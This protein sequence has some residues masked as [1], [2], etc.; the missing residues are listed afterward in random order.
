[1]ADTDQGRFGFAAVF[2]ESGL[3]V[4]EPFFSQDKRGY[5]MK[6]FEASFFEDHGLDADVCEQFDSFSYRNVVRGLHFQTENPQ[7]KLVRCIKGEIFDV[8]VD[9]RSDSP[10]YGKWHAEILSGD[11]MKSYFIP[12]GF[13]HGFQV[14][15]DEALV[16]YLCNGL[17]SPGTDTGILWNDPDLAISWPICDDVILSERDGS[18]MSF[19]DFDTEFGGL[20]LT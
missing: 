18:H 4:I 9:L 10:T 6:S 7:S 13:A 1:M 20:A 16:S 14:L 3:C 12:R 15:S 8:A 11:N 5:F 19:A 2:E 17:Y